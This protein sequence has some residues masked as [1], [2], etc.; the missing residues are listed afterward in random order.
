LYE[1]YYEK[2]ENAEEATLKVLAHKEKHLDKLL[3]LDAPYI[4]NTVR[5]SKK[6]PLDKFFRMG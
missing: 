1:Q 6:G 5:A 3:F 2:L 4:Q